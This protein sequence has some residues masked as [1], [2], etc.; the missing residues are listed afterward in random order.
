MLWREMLA[1]L[2][3]CPVKTVTCKE[4]PALGVAILALVGAGVYE[5][6]QAAC[7]EIIKVADTQ[8]PSEERSAE[9]EKFYSIY[10]ALYPSI[11]EH[12]KMLSKI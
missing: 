10:K 5:S 6:V 8:A 4:G 1:D 2:Y 11:K 12:Y 9:Y 7:S 3:K